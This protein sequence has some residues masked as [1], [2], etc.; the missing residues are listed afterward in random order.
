MRLYTELELKQIEAWLLD[1]LSCQEV[2][3]RVGKSSASISQLRYKRFPHIPRHQ[4]KFD[5][6]EENLAIAQKLLD[7]ENTKSVMAHFGISLSSIK[8][9]IKIGKLVRNKNKSVPWTEKDINFLINKC[10][11]WSVAR[12]A[13]KLG[14]SVGAIEKKLHDLRKAHDVGSGRT[15]LG[16]WSATEV[17]RLLGVSHVTIL[18]AI[19]DRDLKANRYT[20]HYSIPPC[21]LLRFLEKAKKSDRYQ[22]LKNIPQD[23]IDWII[24]CRDGAYWGS[25]ETH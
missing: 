8:W 21:A 9:Q 22:K 15:E 25:R 5:W 3:S 10:G 20:R 6:S 12:I 19:K 13:K 24:E 17:G 2:G 4:L 23:T 18:R 11:A 7:T 14:R 16:D 1:G